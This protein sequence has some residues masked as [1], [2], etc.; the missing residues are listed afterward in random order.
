MFEVYANS[1]EGLDTAR[2]LHE[3]F[4]N[5]KGVE[6]GFGKYSSQ[7]L[8]RLVE[9]TIDINKVENGGNAKVIQVDA[10]LADFTRVDYLISLGLPFYSQ[11]VA[12]EV[13]INAATYKVKDIIFSPSVKNSVFYYLDDVKKIGKNGKELYFYKLKD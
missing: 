5:K 3:L 13:M 9:Y 8:S 12:K 2:V 11:Q 4:K 10:R 6:V 7:S 1:I